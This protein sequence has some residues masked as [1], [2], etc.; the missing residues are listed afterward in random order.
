MV[1]VIV[2]SSN[3]SF[4]SYL[5]RQKIGLLDCDWVK[6]NKMLMD[7]SMFVFNTNG[8][9]LNFPKQPRKLKKS[10]PIFGSQNM[11]RFK[12]PV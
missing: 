3:M 9:S 8:L 2:V 12:S 11:K 10:D 4:V 7:T 5:E 1:T 6:T